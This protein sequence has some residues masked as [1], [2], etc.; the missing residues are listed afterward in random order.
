MK[1]SSQSIIKEHINEVDLKTYIV[2]YDLKLFRYEPLVECLLD[3]L[4]EFAFGFHEGILESYDRNILIDAAKSIYKISQTVNGKTIQVFD[5]VRKIYLD[6]NSELEDSA[7]NQYLK[8]GEFGELILHMFLR[9]FMGTTPLISKIYFKDSSGMTVHGFDAIHIGPSI[10]NNESK[11]LYL[12]ESKL[13]GTGESGIK[14]LVKDIESHF[15]RDFLSEEFTLVGRKK[16]SFI[17]PSKLDVGD[18][19]KYEEFIKDKDYW[20]DLLEKV[21]TGEIKLQ[22]LFTDVTIPMLCTYTSETLTHNDDETS[23]KFKTELEAEVR[24]LKNIFDVELKK[25][26][27]QFSGSGEPISTP[28]NIVLIL[29]PVP[30]KKEL[31]KRLHTKLYY[32]QNA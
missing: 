21:Q 28:L 20:F 7:E 15:K 26:K 8:R 4:V 22:D 6:N 12:G 32:Q 31:V 9:D 11:S 5:E 10:S 16:N 30:S 25:L 19:S 29:F 14:D 24:K 17:D 2:G 3:K 13:Y 23:E 1:N 18:R 27:L